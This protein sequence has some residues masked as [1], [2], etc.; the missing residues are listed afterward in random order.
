MLIPLQQYLVSLLP[1]PVSFL[2]LQWALFLNNFPTLYFVYDMP[3]CAYSK[4]LSK[5]N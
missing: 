2:Q 3:F 1:I 4:T 5:S